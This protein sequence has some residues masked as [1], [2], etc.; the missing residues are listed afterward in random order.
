MLNWQGLIDFGA[1]LPKSID[2][3]YVFIF[4]GIVVT[5]MMIRPLVHWIV[6]SKSITLLN[7][8]IVSLLFL[9]FLLGG[10]VLTAILRLSLLEVALHSLAAFGVCL[11]MSYIIQFIFRRKVKRV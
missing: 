4:S 6:V 5:Y 10:I 9:V 7:Y 11:V 8:V 1:L 3:S 2:L